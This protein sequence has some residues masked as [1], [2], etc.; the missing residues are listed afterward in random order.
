MVIEGFW[1]EFLSA[2]NKNP[3]LK[4]TGDW[5][6]DLPEHETN[7]LINLILSGKKT[8]TT[9]CLLSYEIENDTLPQV[10]EYDILTDLDGNPLCVLQTTNVTVLPFKDVTFDICKREGENDSIE[11]WQALHREFF[12]KEGKELGYI[13][14]DDALVV[15]EDFEVVYSKSS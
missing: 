14:T 15:F 9:S 2:T 4:H 1:Q 10:G 12:I 3:L 6:F 5:C 13:F 7:Y 8:A 11:S